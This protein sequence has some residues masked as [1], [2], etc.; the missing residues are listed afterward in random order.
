MSELFRVLR[1]GGMALIMVPLHS[2]L[3]T[4]Y[5]DPSIISHSGRD[6]AFGEW[7]FVRKYGRDFVDRLKQAGFGIEIVQPADRLDEAT[8]TTYGIWNDRIYVCRRPEQMKPS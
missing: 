7:D 6:K 3:E 5:E 1:P 8:R 2:D 4:T